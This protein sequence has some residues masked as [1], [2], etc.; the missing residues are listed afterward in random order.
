MNRSQ[1]VIENPAIPY[2]HVLIFFLA[3]CARRT[4]RTQKPDQSTQLEQGKYWH[5]ILYTKCAA[6]IGLRA[7]F[8]VNHR[9]KKGGKQCEW[10][11]PEW[12][13]PG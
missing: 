13:R 7:A 3:F 10:F 4:N 2:C 9:V 8:F 6:W 11:C 5:Q 12:H 1:V